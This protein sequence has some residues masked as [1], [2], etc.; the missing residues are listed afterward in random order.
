MPRPKL[1]PTPEQRYQVKCLAAVGTSQED[2]ARKIGIRSEKTLRKY[3]REEL[4]L[5]AID[6]NAS[7]GGALYNKAIAGN[8]EAQKFW[9]ERRAG[10]TNWQHA[11][12]LYAPPPFVVAR[13]KTE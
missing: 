13:E 7:V 5:A 2:I 1:T 6:A 4:D 10:W 9:L 11:S 8:T 12:G 3:F